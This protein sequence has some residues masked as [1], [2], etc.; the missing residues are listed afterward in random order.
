[1]RLRVQTIEEVIEIIKNDHIVILISE[2]DEILLN[3]KQ[4]FVDLIV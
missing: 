3:D 2:I 1:M 4:K